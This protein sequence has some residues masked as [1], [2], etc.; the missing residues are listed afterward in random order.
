MY[1]HPVDDFLRS[2]TGV[3]LVVKLPTGDDMHIGAGFRQMERQIAQDLTC[4]R[5]VG[6]K[7]L[8]DEDDSSRCDVRA[9]QGAARRESRGKPAP[10][11]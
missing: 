1:C 2:E 9:L 4:R 7:V 6:R 10:I 5:V 11:G 3:R 8:I